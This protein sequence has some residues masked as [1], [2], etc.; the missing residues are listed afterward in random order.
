ME[1]HAV[2]LIRP[3]NID[4]INFAFM[5]PNSAL[6]SSLQRVSIIIF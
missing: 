3:K 1:F 6:V 4:D 2:I 5:N